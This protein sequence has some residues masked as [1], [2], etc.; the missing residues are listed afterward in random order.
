[1]RSIADQKLLKCYTITS[2]KITVTVPMKNNNCFNLIRMLAAFLVL[3]QH[4][5]GM[6]KYPHTTIGGIIGM[7]SFY[8]FVFITLSG[9]L[10]THSFVTSDGFVDYLAKRVKRIFPAL[11]FC[12]F[13]V[14]YLLI[15]FY[16]TSP[17]GYIFSEKT[18]KGFL[19]M[20]LLH[21]I[22]IPGAENIY[23]HKM[24]ANAP[25]WS[26]IYEFTLY[27]LIGLFLGIS[28]NWKSS[29]VAVVV[30]MFIL[31]S[32]KEIAEKYNFYGMDIIT[33]AKFGVGFS[34]GSLMFLTKSAWDNSK[35]KI[36]CSI[37]CILVI[38]SIIGNKVDIDSVGRICVAILIIMTG[39][40]FNDI[41]IKGRVD[42]S[43]GVYIWAWPVQSIVIYSS[44]NLTFYPSLMLT[45]LI[46]CLVSAFSRVYIEEP[47]MKRK[48]RRSI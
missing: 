7:E 6:M 37:F 10:V 14:T 36:P 35:F 34:I 13:V 23:G 8:V 31:L 1:M 15:P 4:H 11:I 41:Y 42:I 32:P 44:L 12:C 20:S 5:A 39:V 2:L 30:F 25:L 27:L 38:Y 3:I 21:G 47:F 17:L 33:L 29:A 24:W 9:Y 45:I 28:K 40:S 19:G 48:T 43:Y 18:F 22:T 46:T 26:L 16:E